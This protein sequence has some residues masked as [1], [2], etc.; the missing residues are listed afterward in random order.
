MSNP[1]RDDDEEITPQSQLDNPPARPSPTFP[2][3]T[4]PPGFEDGGRPDR[5]RAD[6]VF[7]I[8]GELN[9]VG[10]F[11]VW[12][13]QPIVYFTVLAFMLLLSIPL[14]PVSIIGGP[15]ATGLIAVLGVMVFFKKIT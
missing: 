10:R 11:R 5:V 13:S 12:A 7:L 14:W 2:G 6:P 15:V 4:L 8:E 1:P 3:W 9:K